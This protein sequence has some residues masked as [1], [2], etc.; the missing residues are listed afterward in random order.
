MSEVQLILVLWFVGVLTEAITGAL[1][2]GRNRMDLFG[3]V[4]VACIT[5]IGGGTVRDIL[6]G[7]YPLIWVAHPHYLLAIALAALMT[8]AFSPLMRYLTRLFLT[9][10][11]LGLTVFSIIGVQKALS[12]GHP[13]LIAIASGLI[14]GVFGGILRDLFCQRVPLVFRKELYAMVSLVTAALYMG[15]T[16]AEASE[17]LK[18]AICLPLGFGLRLLAIR[19]RWSIPTFDYQEQGVH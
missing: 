16:M 3:V 12:L 14:T 6:L 17:W 8:V 9:L 11:A 13:P 7:G 1:A 15:L 4:M 2:A 5:A 19:Y 10:D 18:L